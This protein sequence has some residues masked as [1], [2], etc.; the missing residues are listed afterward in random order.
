MSFRMWKKILIPWEHDSITSI[1]KGIHSD[2][3]QNILA[4]NQEVQQ[5]SDVPISLA[6]P[7]LIS[8]S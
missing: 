7:K 6:I 3:M 8:F 5:R 1:E 4:A 2:F